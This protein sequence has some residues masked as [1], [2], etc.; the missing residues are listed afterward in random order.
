MVISLALFINSLITFFLFLNYFFCAIGDLNKWYLEN[1]DIPDSDDETFALNFESGTVDEQR[2]F[3]FVISTKRLLKILLSV[4]QLCVDATY[5]LNWFGYPMMVIG[6]VDKNKKFNPLA[7]A[8]CSFE[9]KADYE[10]I[11]DAIK[12]SIKALFDEDFAPEILVSDAAP[13]I[14]NAFFASFHSSAKV[15]ITCWAHVSRA[16]RQK[17]KG[18]GYENEIMNDIAILQL[19]SSRKIFNCATRLFIK[20]WK[21]HGLIDFCNYFKKEWVDKNSNW[22][23]GVAAYTPSTNNGLE[24]YNNIIKKFETFRQK[25]QFS[26]FIAMMTNMTNGVSTSFANGDRV[27]ASK[28]NVTIDQWRLA[29][30]FS[31]DEE[32]RPSFIKNETEQ[33]I[34]FFVPSKKFI[35]AEYELSKANCSAALER[36]HYKNFEEYKNDGFNL[37]YLVT[38]T[39]SDIFEK[40]TC[41]CRNFHKDFICQHILG[42]SIRNEFCICPSIADQHEIGARPKRGRKKM[43]TSALIRD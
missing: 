12:K 38:L 20:K 8:C 33:K 39:K 2:F 11:F 30:A 41:T 10:F 17:C 26:R 32:N 3:R 23:E 22:F 36:T 27:I 42:L 4:K 31:I 19:S 28:R 6:T 9:K 1:R 5:K 7:F 16:I 21:R 37:V 24:A 13:A 40:S 34:C 14:K 43:A 15:N 35:D 18:T 29:S 25:L